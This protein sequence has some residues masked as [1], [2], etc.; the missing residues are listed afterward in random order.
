MSSKK[1]NCVAFKGGEIME[2]IKYQNGIKAMFLVATLSILSI[3][4]NFLVAPFF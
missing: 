1:T 2:V 4:A 3:I